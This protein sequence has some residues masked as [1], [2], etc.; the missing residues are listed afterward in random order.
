MTIS[1]SGPAKSRPP[2]EGVLGFKVG[3][4]RA[5]LE[6]APFTLNRFWALGLQLQASENPFK[7]KVPL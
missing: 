1:W 2:P 3:Y 4:G 6:A 5:L 7:P